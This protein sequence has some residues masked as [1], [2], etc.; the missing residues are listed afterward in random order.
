[1]EVVVPLEIRFGHEN[2]ANYRR[3]AYKWWF[4]LAE[5]VDNSTQS[6]YDNTSSLDPVLSKEGDQFTV[7]IST[8][9]DLIRIRDNALG[10]DYD[11]LGRAM[12]VGVP[13]Q[14]TKGR[15]Q[16]G[17]GM[18]TAACWIGDNWKII[19]TKLGDS[20]EYTVLVDVNDVVDGNVS[21]PVSKRDVAESEHYTL[22]E[23]TSHHRPLKGRTISKVK[24]YL[25][26]I[27]RKDISSG[28][29]MLYYNDQELEW[30]GFSDDDFLKRNDGTVYKGE[31]IFEIDTEPKKV[32]EGWVGVL[33]RGSRSKAGFSIL[34]RQRLIKGWP[35]SWRPETV[36]GQ[37]GRNDL[38]NQRVV[39]EINLEDFE[40]SH[41]K[42]EINWDGEEEELVEKGLLKYCKPFMETARKARRGRPAEHGPSDVQVDAAIKALEEELKTPKFLEALE[43]EEVLPSVSQIE[44]GNRNVVEN[45]S[46]KDPDF[47]VSLSDMTIKVYIDAIG[48]PNDPYFVNQDIDEQNLVIVVNRQHPHWLMLEGNSIENYLRHC[49]YDGVAEHR[50]AR[51]DRLESDT[52]KKL[53]DN[54]LRVAFEVLQST[55]EE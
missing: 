11:D 40:V 41:T 14:N 15:S 3:L 36:Y 45:A 54:Y 42:D 20:N 7:T 44:E 5:F 29:M 32:A 53:K 35:D 6:Y 51:R 2:F 30:R 17:L 33:R 19:T 49:V 23:I 55:E 37:G 18:K 31:Y 34:H 9:H 16:Y 25:E 1:M 48:S 13:P 21:P 26:S 22:I 38:I 24:E 28:Q 4:A 8:D 39:G 52:V 10:M 27:Y 50:A 12:R 46:N 47:V 43:M